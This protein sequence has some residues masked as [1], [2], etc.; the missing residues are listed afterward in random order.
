MPATALPTIATMATAPG[1][2]G[3]VRSA[4]AQQRTFLAGLLGTDGEVWT[5]LATLGVPL[6][7]YVAQTAAVTVTAAERGT[8][9]G[10]SGTWAMTLPGAASAGSAWGIAL[11]NIGS[12]TITL[13]PAGSDTIDGAASVQ[14]DAGRAAFIVSTGSGWI[15]IQTQS[16]L[17]T[18][19]LAGLMS[20]TDKQKIDGNDTLLILQNT[21]SPTKKGRFDLAGVTA[22]QTRVW[23]MPN[24]NALLAVHAFFDTRSAALTFLS[25]ETLADGSQIVI[26]G[27]GFR[28]K[29]GA[30]AISDMAGWLPAGDI[31]ADHFGENT[32]PGT[33]DMSAAI[34]AA[35]TYVGSLGGGFVRLL[36]GTYI[37]AAL[38]C[39]N[40][41]FLVGQG[42]SATVLKL[43]NGAN[44]Y[45]FASSNWVANVTYAALGGGAANLTF[46]GNVANNATGSL[47]WFTSYRALFD[48]C[49]FINSGGAGLV[50]SAIMQNGT[51]LLTNG[52]AETQVTRCDLAYNTTHG[53]H[54]R[55]GAANRVADQEI[56]YCHAHNNGGAG[57]YAERT[58]GWKIHDNQV[59]SN[60]T[61]CIYVNE[62]ARCSIR[63]N[64]L[65]L[66]AGSVAGGGVGACIYVDTFSTQGAMGI[67]DNTLI[68]N[69]DTATKTL[70]GI[71]IN[72]TSTDANGIGQNE[73]T[74]ISAALLGVRLWFSTAALASNAKLEQAIIGTGP[75]G[76]L[77]RTDQNFVLA[78]PVDATKR[79]ILHIFSTHPTGT[80][81][82]FYLPPVGGTFAVL[83]RANQSWSGNHTFAGTVRSTNPA[84]AGYATG[85]GGP[86]T[87]ITS[88]ATA[89]SLH[90]ASGQ[91]TTHNAALAAGASV[92]FTVNCSVIPAAPMSAA[93]LA[94]VASPSGKYRVEVV[95]I[96]TSSYVLELTN[97]T[98]G[99]LS[100]AVV[101]NVAVLSLATS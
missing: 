31:Y 69:G 54:A 17:A 53:L 52:M 2:H 11:R 47:V 8:L 13:T 4:I 72:G 6:S 76:V 57:I 1:T 45:L 96:G 50:L 97:T 20:A 27:L 75:L 91:I 88:K 64:N 77:T 35:L 15:T 83:E 37:A 5:A 93:I 22:G 55:D 26:R 38:S 46:D 80:L 61:H 56:T 10:A 28:K 25:T 59:Y 74:D 42:K 60:G 73:Y 48:S 84:P 18:T 51:T 92:Q 41:T 9:Y 62:A 101:I 44:T 16:G 87:Q 21:A 65:E 32:T 78:D 89:V 49:A 82:D 70:A 86:I 71:A 43:R 63:R 98:A 95:G 14:I 39:P 34:Q 99:S 23:S 7:K 3:G 68:I 19:A 94:N 30:T 90:K 67:A 58:A 79:A 40:Y 66:T 100:E 36:A 29:T 81:L 12:G 24:M 33:T 85:A